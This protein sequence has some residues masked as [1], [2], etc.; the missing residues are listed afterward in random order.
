MKQSSTIAPSSK[1]EVEE[2][3]PGAWPPAKFRDAELVLSFPVV[4][5]L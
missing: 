2:D 1:D 4:S 5:R 3:V